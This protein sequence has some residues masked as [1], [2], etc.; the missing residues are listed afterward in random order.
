MFLTVPG[1]AK[2]ILHTL[3]QKGLRRLKDASTDLQ[4]YR[5][6]AKAAV[7]NQNHDSKGRISNCQQANQIIRKH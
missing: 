4:P 2:R 1:R 3:G 5:L 7:P 6:P